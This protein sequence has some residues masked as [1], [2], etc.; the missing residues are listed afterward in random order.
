MPSPESVKGIRERCDDSATCTPMR[1]P[2]VASDD[3]RSD[4]RTHPFHI[5]DAFQFDDSVTQ[6]AMR[7]RRNCGARQPFANADARRETR[8]RCRNQLFS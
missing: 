6:G 1:A 5:T 3:A 2:A 8:S 7:R 4:V